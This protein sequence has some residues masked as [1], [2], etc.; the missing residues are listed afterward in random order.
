MEREGR[1]RRAYGGG[2]G[3]SG[4]GGGGGLEEGGALNSPLHRGECE[5]AAAAAARVL[6]IWAGDSEKGEEQEGARKKKGNRGKGRLLFFSFSFFFSAENVEE[7][8]RDVWEGR[9]GDRVGI[10]CNM[11]RA[12]GGILQE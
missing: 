7:R 11:D 8:T 3:G 4:G 1:G 5:A 12:N 9:C 6:R 10:A 2:G